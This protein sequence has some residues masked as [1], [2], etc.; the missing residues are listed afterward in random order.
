MREGLLKIYTARNTA[1]PGKMP[2]IK[3]EH[4]T[5]AYYQEEQVGVTR[6]YAAMAANQRIDLLVRC[7]FTENIQDAYAVKLEDGKAYEITLKQQRDDDVMLTLKRMEQY[8]G[9]TEQIE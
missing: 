8:D 7:F 4:L 6:V 3:L 2:V 1:E 9:Y 5:D